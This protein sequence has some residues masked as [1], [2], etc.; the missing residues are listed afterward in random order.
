MSEEWDG[1][2]R[3]DTARRDAFLREIDAAGRSISRRVLIYAAL[4]AAAVAASFQIA[5]TYYVTD[6]VRDQIRGG[7][8]YNCDTAA[9][10]RVQARVR[11][12]AQRQLLKT[13][14]AVLQQSADAQRDLADTLQAQLDAAPPDTAASARRALTRYVDAFRRLERLST[15]AAA[16][17]ITDLAPLI[18]Q[19][20]VEREC[21]TL[22]SDGS[23]PTVTVP[24]SPAL[25][26]AP[27]LLKPQD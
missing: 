5:G 15:S 10:G 3:R 1:V 6:S 7:Q 17:W 23:P 22:F 11:A 20:P 16:Y 8:V 25:P 4:V 12:F 9:V 24:T 21:A 26:P 13:S 19:L 2:E 18:Q 27:P 14:A